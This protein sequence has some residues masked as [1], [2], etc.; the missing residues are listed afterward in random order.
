MLQLH[1]IEYS[2]WTYKARWA[3]AWHGISYRYREYLP[4]VGK[5]G[6]RFRLG[7]WSEPI[8]V[9]VATADKDVYGNSWDIA[10]FADATG[11]GESLATQTDEVAHWNRIADRILELG[12]IR[13]SLAV[14]RDRGAQRASLPKPLRFMPGA[15]V[16]ARL[17]VQYMLKTYPVESAHDRLTIEMADILEEIS[18][19]LVG[20]DYLLDRFSYADMTIAASL[21]MVHPVHGPFIPLE[22]AVRPHWYHQELAEAFAPLC[23]W[24]DALFDAHNAPQLTRSPSAGDR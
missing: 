9:P 5:L 22:D 7:R 11:T 4:M 24:R 21:Q 12:R 1:G 16:L 13:I 20:R 10:R 19:A 3:L 8:T 15:T 18:D 23:L 14:A 17:G 6:M 2:P